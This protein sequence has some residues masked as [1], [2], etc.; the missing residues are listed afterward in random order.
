MSEGG[1]P[2]FSYSLQTCATQTSV[3]NTAGSHH[4]KC[5]CFSK[6]K[7]GLVLFVV[8][9]FMG[10]GSLSFYLSSAVLP[11]SFYCLL[12]AC[13]FMKGRVWSREDG[14]HQKGH[15]V[16]G[17]CC[18]LAQRTKRPHSCE[19]IPTRPPLPLLSFTHS[20]TLTL[21]L[22]LT[23]TI[24]RLW[25]TWDLKPVREITFPKSN[26]PIIRY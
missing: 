5:A 20:H 8:L 23:H 21:T 26:K 25:S 18:L 10:G 12:C 14:E 9:F 1:S 19:C 22:T 3:L 16:P 13:P 15:P 4:R 11:P 6:A 2:Y 7:L 17:P 24:P